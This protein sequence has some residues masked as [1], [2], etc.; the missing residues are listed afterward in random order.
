MKNL[1]VIIQP[2]A[3]DYYAGQLPYE[4]VNPIGVWYDF[5]PTPEMQKDHDTDTMACVTFSA[6]NILETQ[7]YFLTGQRINFSDRFI[8]KV[9]GTTQQ[10][11]TCQA[12]LDAIRHY[13]L[14]LESDYP[15]PTDF[16]WNEYYAPIPNEVFGKAILKPIN[17]VS[18]V[19]YEFGATDYAKELKQAPLQMLIEKG[20]P[21]HAVEMV[22]LTH[23][24]NSYPPY[25][26]PQKSIY[27]VVKIILKG[28]PMS[29]TKIILDKDGK[30]LM[31]G[32]PITT[33][34]ALISQGKNFGV[35]IPHSDDHTPDW[36]AVNQMTYGKIVD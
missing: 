2:K 34:E 18:P 7:Y 4:V 23:Q 16:D 30:T 6:L 27:T 13:G 22:S 28:V 1:G 31:W 19:S 15:T 25:H 5:E 11:N 17:G 36:N 35:D 9:S 32:L 26:E 29:N 14:V 8:A 3:S 20:N 24:F 21:Y 33:P 12:V 10:G